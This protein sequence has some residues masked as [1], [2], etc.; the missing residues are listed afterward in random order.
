MFNG[1]RSV[2][3]LVMLLGLF[4]LSLPII[5]A[6]FIASNLNIQLKSSKRVNSIFIGTIFILLCIVLLNLF[7]FLFPGYETF[8]VI[9][10]FDFI[11][12]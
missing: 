8:P 10:I 2:D 9:S 3:I 1:L 7:A 6:G 12:Y 11:I 4:G 5:L